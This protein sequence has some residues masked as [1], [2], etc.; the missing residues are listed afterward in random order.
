MYAPGTWR[1]LT[2]DILVII[3]PVVM[4]TAGMVLFFIGIHGIGPVGDGDSLIVAIRK[5][6]QS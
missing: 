2:E 1:N 5:S 4:M 3:P 6:G